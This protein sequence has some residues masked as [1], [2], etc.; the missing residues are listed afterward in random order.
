MSAKSYL[1]LDAYFAVG[2]SFVELYRIDNNGDLEEIKRFDW[3]QRPSQATGANQRFE[4]AMKVRQYLTA[5]SP[6]VK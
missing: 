2:E 5:V 3:V 1:V 4:R 6:A